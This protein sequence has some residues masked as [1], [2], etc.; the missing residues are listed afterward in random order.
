MNRL[1]AFLVAALLLGLLL[2]LPILETASAEGERD[3]Q[4][5]LYEE[6]GDG[7]MHTRTEGGQGNASSVTIAAGGDFNFALTDEQDR[8]LRAALTLESYRSGAAAHAWVWACVDALFGGS[9]LELWLIDA[10]NREGTS[11]TTLARGEMTV[12][13]NC[14]SFAEPDAN[15]N[16]NFDLVWESGIGPDYELA[17]DR[18]VVVRAYNTG[19][20]DAIKVGI[21]SGADGETPTSLEV[22]T[23]PVSEVSLESEAL[24]LATLDDDDRIATANFEP[25]LPAELAQAFFSGTALNAFGAYDVKAL[26]VDVYDPGD[27]PG[28]A[29]RFSGSATLATRGVGSGY[30]DYS[31]LTWRYNDPDNPSQKQQGVG[32]YQVR[33]T[34]VNQQDLEFTADFA[35]QMDLYGVYVETAQPEQTVAVGGTATYQLQVYNSGAQSDTVVITPSETPGDWTVSPD[36]WESGSLNSGGSDTATFTVEVAN[37]VEMVGDSTVISFSAESQTAPASQPKVFALTTTTTVGAEYGVSLYFDQDGQH[38]TSQQVEAVAGEWNSFTLMVSNLGQAADSIDL[39]A[40]G[41]LPGWDVEFEYENVSSSG[42]TVNLPRQGDGNHIASVTVLVE[43]TEAGEEDIS[44]IQLTGTSQGNSSKTASA[45]LEVTRTFGLSLRVAQDGSTS[46]G[47]LQPGGTQEV[48]LTL[49]SE[50]EDSHTARLYTQGLESGWSA[51]FKQSGQTVTEVE[52]DSGESLPLDLVVTVASSANYRDGGYLVEAFAEDVG[53]PL[54]RSR[55]VLTFNMALAA[56]FQ[57][58]SPQKRAAVGPGEAHS[59][60]LEIDN[61]GNTNDNYTLQAPSVP[62]GW[63]VS[64]YDS[65]GNSVGVLPVEAGRTELVK[66]R[67]TASDDVRNGDSEAIT[68][69]ATSEFSR[70]QEELVFTVEIEEGFGARLSRTLGDLWYVFVLLGLLMAVG[71]AM[72]YRSEDWEEDEEWDEESDEPSPAPAADSTG[73]DWDDWE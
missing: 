60:T 21:D 11:G 17:Q 4:L 54:V 71:A 9:T 50:L 43:P 67:V 36:T 49:H 10:S 27:E 1:P 3:I 68:V 32:T 23:N 70:D 29:P 46:Y 58:S 51:Q 13:T 39:S 28:D 6:G 25:E 45:T 73:D 7:Y 41:Q 56:D 40:S 62:S 44:S 12:D 72:Y 33:A 66:V 30:V 35:L 19:D 42:V 5:Y 16:D 48:H 22:T 69:T 18:Y 20:D 64:F 2:P 63:R 26:R 47:N 53:D 34:V 38:L 61:L 37:D 57:L 31:G 8:G 59:F 24:N 14:P 55:L 52:I 15:D 65:D